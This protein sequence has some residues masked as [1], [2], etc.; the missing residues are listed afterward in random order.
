MHEGVTAVY[1]SNVDLFFCVLGAQ[2]ENEVREFLITCTVLM[3]PPPLQLMLV[4]VL[5]ALYD[6]INSLLKYV[7]LLNEL[8]LMSIILFDCC[9][10]LI[11][12]LLL[13]ATCL[14]HYQA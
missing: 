3:I 12:P 2:N 6:S 11:I 13:C 10:Q 5:N 1:K 7:D 8:C 4:G 9:P 14:F